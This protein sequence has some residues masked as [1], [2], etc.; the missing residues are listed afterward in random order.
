[1]T[2][3]STEEENYVRMS[4]LLTGIS[5][6][7]VRVLFD[8]EFHPSCLDSTLKKA[9]NKLIDLKETCNK[10]SAVNLMF[11]R[12]P[13]VPDSKTFDITL[14][15]TLLRNLAT[16]SPPACE[17][18]DLPSATE[19]MLGADLTRI[20]YY[21]NYMAHLGYGKIDTSFFNTAWNNITNAI[22]R[23][24]GQQMKQECDYLNTKPLDQ[25]NQEIMLDIKRSNDEIRELKESF[26]SLKMSHTEIKKSHELLQEEHADVSR[27]LQKL[28]TSQEDTVPW[29]LRGKHLEYSFA[30]L[31][32][33]ISCYG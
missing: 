25:T 27:K 5:P 16:I 4:L 12:F 21:R 26:K 29:N 10:C 22:E 13:D 14:M 17:F 19:T 33:E 8:S 2:S 1:M 7:A 31:N 28:E 20:K 32:L 23:L 24:G 9:Y 3:I 6:R 30:Q 11:T 15:I 18:D